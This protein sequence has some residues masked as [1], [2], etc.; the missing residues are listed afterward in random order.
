MTTV[1]ATSTPA[2]EQPRLT[3]LTR[4]AARRGVRAAPFGAAVGAILGLI[5]GGADN[6]LTS[7]ETSLMMAALLGFGL[8]PATVA[9]ISV[10]RGVRFSTGRALGRWGVGIGSA[11][12]AGVAW[13]A[14]GAVVTHG[15]G[16]IVDLNLDLGAL[17]TTAIGASA[18]AGGISGLLVMLASLTAR[19][20]ATATAS[21][22][23][24]TTAH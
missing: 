6:G 9:A 11:L 19:A 24:L 3:T 13:G 8:V 7:N 18:L 20:P 4:L 17:L 1:T 2:L 21:G 12:L 16:S 5:G 10:A 23:N 14:I 15:A 22:T